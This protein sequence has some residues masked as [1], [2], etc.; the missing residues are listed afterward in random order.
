M[1][2]T[3]ILSDNGVSSGS[4]GL[5]STAGND[6][7]LILQTTTSGG[8]ATNAIYV[9]TSQNVGLGATPS[10]W[11]GFSAVLQQRG[12]SHVV[13]DTGAFTQIG[14]N[15]YYNGTN[16]IYTTT[17]PASRFV[18]N[19]GLFQWFSAASGTAGNAITFTTVASVNKDT[20][21]VLQ[22]GTSSS[23]TGIAFPATQSASSDANTLD[24]YEE[25]TWT[26]T[27]GG[28]ATYSI[29][30][31][32]Y[33]KVGRQ[34]IANF[35][36]SV[37]TIGTGNSTEIFGLPFGAYTGTGPDGLAGSIGYFAGLATNVVSLYLRTDKGQTKFYIWSL[38]AAQGT[39]SQNALFTSGTR[40]TGTIIYIAST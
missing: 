21:F 28:T 25:G 26:P 40:I 20:T 10:A 15:N 31:G 32:T 22:G 5:K 24:D 37:S 14:A 16:W 3:I 9:D 1:A 7:V 13:G 19:N 18:Q 39:V 12:G 6:G 17:A 30:Q 34:V 8:T 11:S 27:L 4:A 23:G 38:T 36:V 2:S 35:D 33:T 29:Q